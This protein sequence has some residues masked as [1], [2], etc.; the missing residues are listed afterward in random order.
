MRVPPLAL[1]YIPGPG[2]SPVHTPDSLI[3]LNATCPIEDVK[4]FEFHS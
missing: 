2:P 4:G 3:D 1:F